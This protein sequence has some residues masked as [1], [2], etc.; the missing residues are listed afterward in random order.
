MKS[1]LVRLRR[2][3]IASA[4]GLLLLGALVACGS[5]PPMSDAEATSEE[6][7]GAA[8][9][10]APIG[11]VPPPAAA[12]DP[13]DVAFYLEAARTAWRLIERN[14]SPET[15][16]ISA[17]THYEFATTWDIGSGLGALYAAKELGIL[18][19]DEYRTRMARM[20]ETLVRAPLFD[21]VAYHKVYSTR[22]GGM[23]DRRSQPSTRGYGWSATDLGR[24]L[25]WLRI[26]AGDGDGDFRPLAQQ[27]VDRMDFSTIV[28][29]GYMRGRFV[30]GNLFQEGRIGYEQYVATGFALWDHPPQ[31]ALDAHRHLEMTT[32]LG[33]PVPRDRRGLDRLRSEPFVMMG[34][35]VG[36]TPEMRDFAR[37]VLDVQ[38]ARYEQTGQVTI[39]SEDAVSVAPHHFYYYCV[40][41]NGQ[42]FVIDISEPGEVRDSPR[43]VSTKNAFGWHALL[44]DDYTALALEAVGGARGEQGWASGVFEGTGESTQTY[45]I[46]TA[47]VILEAA[48]YMQKGGPILA[49]VGRSD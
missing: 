12:P 48:L 49:S 13:E 15:G 14:Y 11:E 46:N 19:K 22:T 27:I 35:E 16:L 45:D 47:A 20:L 38:R 36:W 32:V 30:E 29:D 39:V 23:V 6:L 9:Q 43:W 40:L 2:L 10:A 1:P 3:R 33:K 4:A 24:F 5:G 21:G 31:N 28:Q 37:A 25:I 7:G 42:A 34:L 17:T 18:P 26:V 41:C 8:L 44:P